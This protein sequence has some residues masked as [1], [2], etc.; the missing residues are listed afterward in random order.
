MKTKDRWVAQ[1]LLPVL[2][3]LPALGSGKSACAM[4]EPG[5]A[6][7]GPRCRSTEKLTNE[8]RM[9]MKTKDRRVAQALLPV[10]AGQP[11]LHTEQSGLGSGGARP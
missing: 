1:A 7:L 3:S 6:P 5:S 4:P 10:L 8:P 2:V 11:A 9:S